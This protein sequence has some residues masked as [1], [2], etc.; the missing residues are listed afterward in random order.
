MECMEARRMIRRASRMAIGVALAVAP[1]VADFSYE[2]TTRITGG[3]MAGMMRVAGV[4][5]KT[6]R[7]PIKQTV[8][9]K[10]DRM[11]MLGPDTAHITDLGK[12]TITDINFKNKTYSVITFV[13][14]RQAMA[15][16]QEKMKS[17][18]D[19]EGADRADLDFK[20]S[21]KE[22][23]QTKVISGLTTKEVIMILEMQ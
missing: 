22:T 8:I 23:G 3:A 9:V 4:F 7:E 2:Q 11:V 13:Q 16:L 6:A 21:V 20:A 19:P 14:M 1:L 5:S 18:K 15:Q 12:E 10:G 17:Q